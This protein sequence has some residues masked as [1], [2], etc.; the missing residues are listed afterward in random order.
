MGQNF[1]VKNVHFDA[2]VAFANIN[3]CVLHL[4]NF[5]HFWVLYHL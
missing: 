2:V 5:I 3:S 4:I 1:A